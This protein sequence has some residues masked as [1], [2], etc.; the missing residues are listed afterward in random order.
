MFRC[1]QRSCVLIALVLSPALAASNVAPR[2]VSDQPAAALISVKSAAT[3]VNE[4]SVLASEENAPERQNATVPS[5]PSV[6]KAAEGSD[7]P[8]LASDFPAK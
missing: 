4:R 1:S 8:P 6:I 7:R 5:E 3:G 2:L